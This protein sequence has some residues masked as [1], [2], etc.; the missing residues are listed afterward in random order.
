MHSCCGAILLSCFPALTRATRREPKLSNLKIRKRD[1]W[2]R[3]KLKLRCI[4]RLF[5]CLHD[6][7]SVA[8][9]PGCIHYAP[10]P[11]CTAMPS[12][13]SDT[14]VESVLSGTETL[15]FFEMGVLRRPT[16]GDISMHHVPAISTS[17]FNELLRSS[18]LQVGY[19]PCE[20]RASSYS[21][22]AHS[23]TV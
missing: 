12:C 4:H 3:A 23:R 21:P 16:I 18:L 5:P 19:H 1:A 15:D 2:A 11:H 20:R 17:T 22:N 7:D 14:L 8:D 9:V 10:Q 6:E 13:S